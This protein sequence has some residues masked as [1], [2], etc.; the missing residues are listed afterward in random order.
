MKDHDQNLSAL[1]VREKRRRSNHNKRNRE[2]FIPM[3][4]PVDVAK[5]F[6]MRRVESL[7]EKAPLIFWQGDF[8]QFN[9]AYWEVIS[10]D[11]LK[12]QVFRYVSCF[13]HLTKKSTRSFVGD[14]IENIKSLIFLAAN[15]APPFFINNKELSTN[16]LVVMKNGIL[17][18]GRVLTNDPNCLSPHSWGFSMV[19]PV[20]PLKTCAARIPRIFW[21]ASHSFL[22]MRGL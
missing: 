5:A 12:A 22:S 21:Q 11:Q 19:T 4:D 1:N 2:D 16:R 7:R 3:K 6:L 20:F 9:G 15:A 10:D 8:Y 14:V 13:A 18:I 17:D